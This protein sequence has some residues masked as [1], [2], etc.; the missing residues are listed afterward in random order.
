MDRRIVVVA[1]GSDYESF[2][3]EI[4]EESG[5]GGIIY[6][7]F[8]REDFL[9]NG[10]EMTTNNIDYR[11]IYNIATDPIIMQNFIVDHTGKS[12][13]QKTNSNEICEMLIDWLDGRPVN[14]S[15]SV[16]RARMSMLKRKYFNSIFIRMTH[17]CMLS[18]EVYDGFCRWLKERRKALK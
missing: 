5:K 14:D 11:A 13:Q 9:I 18:S 16:T 4:E 3:K 12:S 2:S 17:Y 15:Y 10:L 1:V 6:T 8:T 7:T